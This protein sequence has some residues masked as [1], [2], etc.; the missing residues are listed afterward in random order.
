LWKVNSEFKNVE[1]K[2]TV[3]N[4]VLVKHKVKTHNRKPR[5]KSPLFFQFDIF[6]ILNPT[7]QMKIRLQILFFL[8]SSLLY[9]QHPTPKLI[10]G[11]K[12]KAVF[13]NSSVKNSWEREPIYIGSIQ[14]EIINKFENNRLLAIENHYENECNKGYIKR[15]KNSLKNTFEGKVDI[16]VDTS[17]NIKFSKVVYHE[18]SSNTF[19]FFYANPVV[20]TNNDSQDVQIGY[21]YYIP[22]IMQ[23]QN[24]K[25][26]WTDIERYYTLDCGNC[27]NMI[28]FKPNEITI[29]TSVIYDGNYETKLRLRL[30][31][32]NFSNIFTGKI[33]RSQIE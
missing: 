15:E 2:K 17:Q 1:L 31:E 6:M 7:L 18:K 24:E 23:A 14:K 16:F 9:S 27:L 4:I 33:N 20:L 30:G 8:I 3:Y 5:T 19:D 28:Y 21:G 22:L 11:I 26:E 32:N 12:N 25:G 10:E 13:Y 29:T